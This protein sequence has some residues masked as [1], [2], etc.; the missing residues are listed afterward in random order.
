M[1]IAAILRI[2]ERSVDLD[3]SISVL[4]AILSCYNLIMK[5]LGRWFFNGLTVISLGLCVLA[6]TML[7][8]HP[9]PIYIGPSNGQSWW[10]YHGDYETR[11]L[12]I[13]L[14][15]DHQGRNYY[16]LEIKPWAI[17]GLS[18]ALPAWWLARRLSA[19]QK[20]HKKDDF[21]DGI[22]PIPQPPS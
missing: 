14:E 15:D 1:K 4:T 7:W 2:S 6:I 3:C 16:S 17:V 11:A 19:L 13:T 22:K 18:A 5:R 10:N 8:K 12:R 20:R 21:P 9:W